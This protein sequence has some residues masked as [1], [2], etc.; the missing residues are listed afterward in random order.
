MAEV[1]YQS[2]A[3]AT[4]DVTWL[5]SL[6]KELQL[7]STDPPSIWC[8]NSSAVAIATNPVLHSKFKHV[9][10]DLFFVREKVADGFL[11]VSEVLAYDQ[12]ADIL[13]KPLLTK[14]IE[15]MSEC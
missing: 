4:S 7:H 15:K 6:L 5:V 3:A 1:E 13:T 11:V 12:I 10:L 2:L 8:N 9:E 14:P